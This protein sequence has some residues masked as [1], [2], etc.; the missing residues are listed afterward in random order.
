MSLEDSSIHDDCSL[1]LNEGTFVLPND[2]DL[3]R[4]IEN[5]EE[6]ALLGQINIGCPTIEENEQLLLYMSKND[7]NELQNVSLMDFINTANEEDN[8][9]GDLFLQSCANATASEFNLCNIPLKLADS[10]VTDAKTDG[11]HQVTDCNQNVSDISSFHHEAIDSGCIENENEEDVN[12]QSNIWNTFIEEVIITRYKC[13]LCTFLA[14]NLLEVQSHLFTTHIKP[15]PSAPQSSKDDLNSISAHS[16]SSHSP[17]HEAAHS[18]DFSE[19]QQQP[20]VQTKR[21]PKV[22]LK[23]E[24]TEFSSTSKRRKGKNK[25]SR[26]ACDWPDCDY[27]GSSAWHLQDHHRIHTGERPYRCEW[28]D[29]GMSF[30]QASSLKAHYRIHTGER[31]YVCPYPMCTKTFSQKSNLTAHQMR[32]EGRKPFVCN[33][34]DCDQRFATKSNLRKHI[35][36]LHQNDKPFGCDFPGCQARFVSGSQLR[37][38]KLVHQQEKRIA[39]DWPKCQYRCHR[40]HDMKMHI[41][42]HTKEKNYVCDFCSKTY[43]RQSHL[44]VHVKQ[45]HADN[46]SNSNDNVDSTFLTTTIEPSTEQQQEI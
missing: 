42:M 5:E 7:D 22:K 12:G 2:S 16:L 11:I 32:H 17:S 40:K 45:V 6:M 10:V 33:W 34:L 36:A 29:C 13:K 28:I 44:T 41:R 8:T 24:V 23:A 37:Y 27:I 18:E 4:T 15:P 1:G 46:N 3:L 9:A 14:E 21:R 26:Y 35:G 30:N 20:A 43:S 19:Q 25:R 31:P 39:C 38:H